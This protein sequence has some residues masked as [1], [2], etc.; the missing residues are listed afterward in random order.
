MNDLTQGKPSRVMIAFA[1]PIAL[2]NIFQLFYSLADTRVVGST[3]GMTALA[4]VGATT[5]ISTLFIGFL[6]GLTNGF[7]ILVAREYGAGKKNGVRRLS[8][9]SLALGF[10]TALLLTVFCV[11]FLPFLLRILNVPSELE[12]E[13][14]SY[15][16][17]ILFGLFATFAYNGCAAILRA[18]GDTT[19][20]LVFLICASFL[21]IILDLVLILVFHMGVAGAALATVV[22]QCA[23]AGASFVYMVKRYE[24]FRFTLEDFRVRKEDAKDL[25][26]SGFSMAIMMSLVFFG[27]LALQCAINTFGNDTIVAHTAAR[28]ITEFYMLPFS[29]LGATMSTYCGQNM[30]ALRKDRI[31]EGLWQALCIAWAWSAGMVV[32]SYTAAPVLIRLVTGISQD[33]IIR[34]ASSYLKFDTLFYFV[35][36]AIALIRN[37]LQGMGEHVVPVYSSLIELVGKVVIACFLTPVFAYWGIIVAEPIVWCLM[38]IPLVVRIRKLL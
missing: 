38:V 5:S 8:A 26:A 6:N 21:N 15:I 2:G 16:R 11:V 18:V 30:G 35:T 20:A 14:I 34:T 23:A 22:S 29:V 3:L 32:L 31:R 36:A 13:A 33:M 27:T 28:K 7:A 1:F 12:T 37:A 10:L 24:M 19:A 25:Y 17:I 9:A 4:A